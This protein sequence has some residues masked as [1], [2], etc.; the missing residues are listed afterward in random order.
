VT[1]ALLW[2]LAIPQSAL[3]LVAPSDPIGTIEGNFSVD[4]NGAAAY[5]IPITV[6]PGTNEVAPDLRLTYNSHQNNG[7][8]GMG[9]TLSGIS[10]ITRCAYTLN[11]DSET[12]FRRVGISLTYEDHFCL[13]GIK[14]IAVQGDYG[15]DG[16]VYHTEK[17][18]WTQI[19]SRGQ[20]G[21]GPC[22]FEAYNK[23]GAK[24]EFATTTDSRI[25]ATGRND[26]TVQ[27]WS[28]AKYTDLNGNYTKI[29][30][31]NQN[32]EYYPIRIDYTGNDRVQPK[33]T[34]QRS[35]QFEYTDRKDVTMSYVAGSTSQISKRL[36]HIKTFVN[37]QLAL[38]YR[39]EY[40]YSGVTERSRL[41]QLK[42][43]EAK[44]VCLPATQLEWQGDQTPQWASPIKFQTGEPDRGHFVSIDVTGDGKSNDLVNIL[45]S[46]NTARFFTYRANGNGSWE[47]P[48]EFNTGEF[49]RGRWLTMDVNGDAK[50]D[51]VNLYELSG[52]G[53]LLTYLATDNGGWQKASDVPFNTYRSFYD[54]WLTLDVNGDGQVDLLNVFLSGGS[55]HFFTYWATGDGNWKAADKSFNT[56]KHGPFSP[57]YDNRQW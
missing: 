9:W 41:T 35:V 13:D 3:A 47:N 23:D 24:L 28:L 43:C 6:P 30:Y 7:Y 29:S 50:T 19:I 37:A 40:E 31:F 49:F 2:I 5:L 14:L 53:Y 22:Y 15:K 34:P 33:L 16:A 12:D 56:W 11:R 55:E 39:F 36:S 20:C 46:G 27:V 1:L 48:T 52:T 38:D 26:G 8:M 10:A 44:N 17:E 32:G 54:E 25:L 18:T 45:E 4:G 51:I 21:N 42:Q 57:F